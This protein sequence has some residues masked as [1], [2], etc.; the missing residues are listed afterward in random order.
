MPCQGAQWEK[1]T[2][3]TQDFQPQH[4]VGPITW[5]RVR[6]QL[7]RAPPKLRVQASHPVFASNATVSPS[8]GSITCDPKAS[9][10]HTHGG[11]QG[12]KRKAP[13]QERI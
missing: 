9:R 6:V 10:Q 12:R 13:K 1:R 11:K 3:V 7:P 2:L 5:L 4:P 8:P